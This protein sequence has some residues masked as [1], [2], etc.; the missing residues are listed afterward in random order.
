[1][2][3]ILY[4]IE[5]T[6]D[7]LEDSLPKGLWYRQKFTLGQLAQ[8]FQVRYFTSDSITFQSE[9]PEGVT[10]CFSPFK[11]SI[12]GIRHIL[13]YLFLILSS[14]QWR[15]SPGVLH[16]IGV[17][18]PFIGLI[19]GLSGLRLV[20]SFHY[21]WAATTR[22]NYHFMQPKSLFSKYI[23]RSV[24]KN[25]NTVI[26]TTLRLKKIAEEEYICQKTI[27][28]PNYVNTDMFFSSK[29]KHPW[30][31]FVGRLHWSKGVDT[32]INA[33]L[34]ISDKIPQH[35]LL[36]VGIGEEQVNLENIARG[37]ANIHFLGPKPYS[38]VAEI[39]NTAEL[40]V[41]PSKT[42]EGHPRALIEAMI[43]GCQCLVSDVPGN[44]DVLIDAGTPEWIFPKDDPI[45]LGDMMCKAIYNPTDLQREYAEKSFSDRIVL[46]AYL[47]ILE[48]WIIN[49]MPE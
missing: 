47:K 44:R 9:M 4:L 29:P 25:S 35:E 32:L 28:L 10:H 46:P 31:V 17:N 40:F 12:Y 37:N 45:A 15:G 30:I 41:L 39:L 8:K 13:Y 34:L 3:P 1:M 18:I 20:T 48:S 22:M 33:F 6:D 14:V 42:T 23:Q 16:L 11:M 26:C 21:N 5:S 24:L 43:S 49:Q 7:R 27:V 19:K 38:R 36:I 2:K